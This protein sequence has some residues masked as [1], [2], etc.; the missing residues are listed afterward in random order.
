MATVICP[1]GCELETEIRR[2]RIGGVS[3]DARLRGPTEIVVGGAG[4][5]SLKLRKKARRAMRRSG[6]GKLGLHIAATSG[7]E[8][9][10]A[11]RRVVLE[12]NG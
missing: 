5:V 1:G 6:S 3:Y 12:R 7:D 10:E 9:V 2:L 11:N 8:I 4:K